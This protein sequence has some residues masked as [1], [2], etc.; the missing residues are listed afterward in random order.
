MLR[1]MSKIINLRQR[2]KAA[3]RAKARATGDQNAAKF[4]RSKV[5]K[6]EAA[7]ETKALTDHLDGH[8]RDP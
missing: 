2:R 7:R 8:K 5:E 1:P 4:G 3:E 6:A